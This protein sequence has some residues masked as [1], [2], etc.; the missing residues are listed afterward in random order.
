[1]LETENNKIKDSLTSIS[2]E[3]LVSET[4]GKKWYLSKTFWVNTVLIAAV[5]L[6]SNTGFIVGPELQ[7]VTI[8]L[9]NLGLRKVTKQEIIW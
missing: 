1:M 2:T 6:Q 8:A 4:T 9:V 5:M 3:V 7:A